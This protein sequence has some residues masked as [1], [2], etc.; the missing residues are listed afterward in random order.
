MNKKI[1]RTVAALAAAAAILGLVIGG[2]GPASADTFYRWGDA[3]HTFY[4]LGNPAAGSVTVEVWVDERDTDTHDYF[5]RGHVRVTKGAKATRVQV[6]LVRLGR[7]TGAGGTLVQTTVSRN[8][9]AAQSVE[10]TTDWVQVLDSFECPDPFEAWT[11][12]T[13]S[14]RWTDGRLSTGVTLLGG[15]SEIDYCPAA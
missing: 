3:D 7:A 14:V 12:G 11:R 9:G 10:M 1:A 2:A 15:R 5:L 4:H 8:S 6:D 13:A